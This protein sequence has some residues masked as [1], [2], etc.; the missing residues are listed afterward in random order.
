MIAL[1]KIKQVSHSDVTNLQEVK[2]L[3][4]N[5]CFSTCEKRNLIFMV[6]FV[7]FNIHGVRAHL[8]RNSSFILQ[9]HS[10]IINALAKQRA[11][12]V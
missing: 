3:N 4:W 11:N 12:H 1:G 9:Q 6:S 5:K 7:F 10:R 8:W 2:L